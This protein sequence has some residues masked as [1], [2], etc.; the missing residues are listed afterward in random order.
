MQLE[1]WKKEMLLQYDMQ[2]KEIAR[3]CRITNR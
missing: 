3:I 2:L 1:Y